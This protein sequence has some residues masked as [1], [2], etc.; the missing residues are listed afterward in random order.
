MKI[1]RGTLQ[2]PDIR[3][4]TGSR[5]IKPI[6]RKSRTYIKKKAGITVPSILR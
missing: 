5:L 6:T 3:T 2:R 1:T 4:I